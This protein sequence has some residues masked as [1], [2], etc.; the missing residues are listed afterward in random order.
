MGLIEQLSAILLIAVG[1]IVVSYIT[2]VLPFMWGVLLKIIRKT[3]REELMDLMQKLNL[4]QELIEQKNKEIELLDAEI[5]RRQETIVTLK[6]V[7]GKYVDRS[8][9][10]PLSR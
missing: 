5:S 6:E 1:A 4:P 3:I 9:L 7:T 8:T 2:I 10:S